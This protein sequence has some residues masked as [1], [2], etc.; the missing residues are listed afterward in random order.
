MNDSPHTHNVRLRRTW[1]FNDSGGWQVE[2]GDTEAHVFSWFWNRLANKPPSA[3]AVRAATR[4]AIRKH[5]RGSVVAGGN[6]VQ[7]RTLQAA[8][9]QAAAEVVW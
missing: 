9:E 8:A 7:R 4:R 1:F 6:V 3:R 5:N 2:Y